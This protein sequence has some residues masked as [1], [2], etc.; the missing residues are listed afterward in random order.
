MLVKLVRG[1]KP[2]KLVKPSR[3]EQFA[4]DRQAMVAEQIA[5]R[6]VRDP[7][8]LAAMRDVPR[9]LFVPRTFS[10]RLTQIGRCPSATTRPFHSPTLSR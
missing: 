6:E 1:G 7:R 9:H 10:G 3:Q 8:V 5:A 4:G 2:D